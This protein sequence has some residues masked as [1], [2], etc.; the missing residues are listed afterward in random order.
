MA[1]P[2]WLI[3]LL[4]FCGSLFAAAPRVITLAPHLTEMAF[5]AGITPVAVSAWSDYPPAAKELEQVANW[6]GLSL[7]HISE[8]TR[9][10][11]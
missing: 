5:A 6:Q 10:V 4:L 3:G 2:L 1:K 8:P 11:R 9:Q 7:I